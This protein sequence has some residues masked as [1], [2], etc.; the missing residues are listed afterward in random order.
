MPRRVDLKERGALVTAA[1]LR[2][3][4]RDGLTAL[5]VRNV[6]DEAGIAAASLRRL[7]P[8]Q[9]DLREHCLVIIEER[10]A[11]RLMALSSTGRTLAL[12]VL[13]QMLPLDPERTT[14]ISAQ[15]QLG[16]LARTDE[17]LTPSARRLNA[18]VGRVCAHA[19]DILAGAGD[20]DTD[21]DLAF[22]TDRLH[23][24]IDGLAIEH[25]WDPTARSAEA[26]LVLLERHLLELGQVNH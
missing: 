14:E 10:V 19:L 26:L 4:E 9:H 24:L 15:V 13:A 25:T 3:L 23:A 21:R 12:D 22:E 2:I 18:G 20:L 8:S 16:M 5:S 6:A 11:A 17:N 7:F 1:C